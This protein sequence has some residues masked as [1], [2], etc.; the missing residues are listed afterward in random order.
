MALFD[1]LR[2]GISLRLIHTCLFVVSVI[3]S[4]VMIISTVRLST[5]FQRVTDATE[6]HLE[7]KQATDELMDASDYLTECA[8]R[9]TVDGERR[10]MDEYFAEAF[11]SKR[12]EEAIERMRADPAA[13]EALTQ[14]QEALA[15]SVS[16]MDREYYAMRLVIEAKGYRT[17]PVILA[18]VKLTPEDV[19]LA[20]EDQMRRA[21]ELVLDDG[22][23]EQKER[24]RLNMQ[25]CADEIDALT[26]RI[27][28]NELEELHHEL[29]L[30]RFIIVLLIVTIL[31]MVW[32]TARLGINPVLR[33]VDRIKADSPIPEVGAN[34]FRYLAK[35][36][37]KMYA[38]YRGSIEHLNYKASHDEL[39]GA[40]NRAGYDI[41]LS[42][43][44][45]SSTYLLLVDVDDFKVINDTYG[46]DTGDKA[47][48]RLV[49]ALEGCFRA[50]DHICRIGGDEFV[51]FM[52]HANDMQ[53]GLVSSKVDLINQQLAEPEDGLPPF[54]VSAGAAFGGDVTDTAELFDRADKALYESKGAGKSRLT[55]H[56]G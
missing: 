19:A 44:D 4:V 39:T 45:L 48:I 56:V 1:R 27:E 55:L 32:L 46:H 2:N 35:A 31:F 17:Y 21:T 12:R 18:D 28:A 10:F 26:R 20:P 34:E 43:I 8:Q 29:D 11:K 52:V 36:Y 33:A 5:S 22:Y 14:L 49:R 41:L 40:Y 47:L 16:L 23:Y 7:L 42:S 15:E 37:N 38:V 6:E 24:I 53:A 30:V 3:M 50:D 9:F 54:S 13:A 25:E 51:I